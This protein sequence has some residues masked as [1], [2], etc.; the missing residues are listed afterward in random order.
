MNYNEINDMEKWVVIKE[1]PIAGTT[2]PINSE[3]HVVHGCV[4]FN[5]G[6]MEPFYQIEFSKLLNTERKKPNYLRKLKNIYNQL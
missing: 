4:Y 6:L 3:I 2:L 5:G 1:C